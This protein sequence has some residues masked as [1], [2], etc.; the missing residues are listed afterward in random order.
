MNIANCKQMK[1]ILDGLLLA[2]EI[3]KEDFP[4]YCYISNCEDDEEYGEKTPN[5]LSEKKRYYIFVVD[6]NRVGEK[7]KI[8]FSLD[9][10]TNI[11]TEEGEVFL[12][13][14]YKPKK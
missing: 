10:N 3:D 14:N 9:L 12:K 5:D 7:K 2:K 6:K 13:K 4:K 11:W 8:L 1:H